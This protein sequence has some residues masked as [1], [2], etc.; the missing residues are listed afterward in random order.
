MKIKERAGG[1][2]RM[3]ISITFEGGSL[4]LNSHSVANR[5]QQP[6]QVFDRQRKFDFN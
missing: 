4:N 3:D 2:T 6:R 1:N 5:I